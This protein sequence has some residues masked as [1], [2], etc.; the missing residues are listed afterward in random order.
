[1][2]PSGIPHPLSYHLQTDAEG[3]AGALPLPLFEACARAEAALGVF[4][5][6]RE[7]EACLQSI[8]IH[9]SIAGA[10]VAHVPRSETVPYV[11]LGR[12]LKFRS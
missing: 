7:G 1:M 4:P 8:H 11:V 6:T 3:L 12:F 2:Q 10:L 5:N 9:G